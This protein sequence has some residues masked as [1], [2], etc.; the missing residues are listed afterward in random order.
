MIR[1]LRHLRDLVAGKTKSGK[2]RS[3]HWRE[4]RAAHLENFP[5]CALCGGTRKIEVHHVKPFHLHPE[6]EL[7]EAN[8]ITLCESGHGGVNCHLAFGHL[9]SFQ[10]INPQV[11]LDCLEW[12]KKLRQAEAA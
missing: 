9:G 8:L 5:T 12:G 7:E 3:S 1:H 2:M 11:R 6:L 4:V 10:R